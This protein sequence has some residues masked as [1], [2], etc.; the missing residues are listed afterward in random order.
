MKKLNNP[1]KQE[2][3]GGADSSK[4]GNTADQRGI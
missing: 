4:G 2:E 3:K 1:R